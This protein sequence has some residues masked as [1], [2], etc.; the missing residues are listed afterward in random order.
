VKISNTIY[1]DDAKYNEEVA[2]LM[3]VKHENIV[4]F[5]GYC[6]DTQGKM[7]DYKGKPVMADVWNRLLCFEYIEGV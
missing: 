1:M 2:C 4:R 3:N 5:L 6:A 7:S